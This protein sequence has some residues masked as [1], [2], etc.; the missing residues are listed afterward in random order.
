MYVLHIPCKPF[1]LLIYSGAKAAVKP[2]LNEA[3]GQEQLG[4]AEIPWV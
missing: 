2:K 4:L 1:M 3:I